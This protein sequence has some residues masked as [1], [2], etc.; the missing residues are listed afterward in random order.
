VPLA[1]PVFFKLARSNEREHSSTREKPF[2]SNNRCHATWPAQNPK[3]T[4]KPKFD[5]KFALVLPIIT[6]HRGSSGWRRWAFRAAM[7]YL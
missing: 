1:V 6:I 5:R 7:E 3:I 2:I 4:L